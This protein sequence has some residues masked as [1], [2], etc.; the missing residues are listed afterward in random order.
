MVM[1]ALWKQRN[2]KLWNNVNISEQQVV[3]HA[4][5]SLCEWE[6][7]QQQKMFE[8]SSSLFKGAIGI[9]MV[10]RDEYGLFRAGRT[11]LKSG[12]MAVKEGEAFGLFEALLWVCNLRCQQVIFE[13]DSKEVVDVVG[14]ATLDFTKFGAIIRSCKQILGMKE[15]SVQHVGRKLI[16]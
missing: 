11:V 5:E 3:F 10:L 8:K 6:Y 13:L 1:W 2:D 12:L 9:G 15:F 16:W 7:A 14:R 4:L